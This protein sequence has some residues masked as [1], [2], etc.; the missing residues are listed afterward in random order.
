MWVFIFF[1]NT[2]FK[3]LEQ[4]DECG[5]VCFLQ[6]LLQLSDPFPQ[7]FDYFYETM[8]IRRSRRGR[9]RGRHEDR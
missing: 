4:S 7:I 6:H 3:I 2:V 5:V 1:V 8:R 9:G